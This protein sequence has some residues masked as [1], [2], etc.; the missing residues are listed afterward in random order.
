MLTDQYRFYV[1]CQRDS[2]EAGP[3]GP[4]GHRRRES[5]PPHALAKGLARDNE[6]K[7]REGLKGNNNNQK[8]ERAERGLLRDGCVSFVLPQ[9]CRG[10][11]QPVAGGQLWSRNQT[12]LLQL[13]V[14]FFQDNTPRGSPG[15]SW[16]RPATQARTS[17]APCWPPFTAEPSIGHDGLAWWL[18]VALALT[19]LLVLWGVSHNAPLP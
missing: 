15:E 5:W 2:N 17:T 19:L 11:G 14:A 7:E 6:P 3:V 12:L 1:F 4:R 10:K 8:E 9:W 13:G 18:H 16:V